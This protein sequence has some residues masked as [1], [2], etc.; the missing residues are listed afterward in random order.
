MDINQKQPNEWVFDIDRAISTWSQFVSRER[1]IRNV[2]LEEL[3][4]HLRDEWE[5]LVRKGLKPEEA[6]EQARK[7][8]GSLDSISSA[9]Q[10]VGFEKV[11]RQ[12]QFKRE[13]GAQFT[14]ALKYVQSAMREVFRHPVFATLNMMGLALALC[15]AIIIGLF[16]QHSLSFDSFHDHA[17]RTYR[18][19]QSRG[20]LGESA[21]PSAG[22]A[23]LIRSEFPGAER[24]AEARGSSGMKRQL[25]VGDQHFM[26][27][28]MLS[29]DSEF[30]DMFS[31]P[32][33]HTSSSSPLSA[34]NTIAITESI[35]E[36]LFGGAD[37]MGQTI[38]YDAT[39]DLVVTAVLFDPPSNTHLP[40]NA[41]VRSFNVP[42]ELNWNRWGD[43]TYVKLHPEAQ[44]VELEKFLD[45]KFKAAQP[46]AISSFKVQP[47][48]DLYLYSE[49]TDNY[50]PTSSPVYVVIFA[51]IGL[52]ILLMAGIN[53]TN[54]ATARTS[55][56]GREVGV[57][58]VVGASRMQLR[59][60]FL[61]E[62][63]F[64]TL[65][66][67]LVAVL[68]AQLVIPEVNT[69]IGESLSLGMANKITFWFALIGVIL[70]LSFGAGIYPAILMA[71]ENPST[72]FSGS[73][74]VGKGRSF[75]RRTLVGLQVAISF[76]MIVSA[77]L[78]SSQLHFIREANL[79][80]DQDQIV[81]IAPRGWSVPQFDAFKQSTLQHTSVVSVAL[82]PP[83]GMGWKSMSWSKKLEGS[84]QGV[85]IEAISVGPDFFETMDMKLVEGRFFQDPDMHLENAPVVVSEAYAAL[86]GGGESMI[87][88]D[89]E[90]SGPII[91]VVK[92][93]HNTSF[94]QGGGLAVYTLEKSYTGTVVVKLASDKIAEG[95]A[96]LDGSWNLHSPDRPFAYEFLDD[97]IQAQYSYEVKLAGIF[98][99]FSTLSMIIAG[100][101][102][103]G[104]ASFT[105]QQ[106]SKEISI[107][108]SLGATDSN[109]VYLLS[110]EF[111]LIVVTGVLVAS[112]LVYLAASD[113]LERFSRHVDLSPTMFILA[114]TACLLVVL[115][116]VSGLAFRAAGSNP[117]DALKCD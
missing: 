74:S 56:R 58:K 22:I 47:I 36:L 53:Y 70:L 66:S 6:F 12:G 65:I 115:L 44:S 16:I 88:L 18:V 48:E 104:L 51:S 54:L 52:F 7:S 76:S 24:V 23:D 96:V 37:P 112:P 62:T 42:V 99:L 40:F 90:L 97:K 39:T 2:D 32:L 92:D 10:E 61:T 89:S 3:E 81:T 94:T 116:P 111:L 49:A 102:L 5:C 55:R 57:R 109:I 93:V 79:G 87:G 72:I 67:L 15:S 85:Q 71:N 77:V 46:G 41:L 117:T 8:I 100:L 31:F 4:I 34:P 68:L 114:A 14:M 63:L 78:I 60:Q 82:G 95:L 11:F 45:D 13:I 105:T 28:R 108:K 19:S 86:F 50:A 69:I 64:L 106:R 1:S 110:K 103:F 35:A 38:R 113:W 73:R 83:L 33:K 75:V 98:N 29:V 20:Q 21:R 91:G 9:Y 84:E 27:D 59:L 26:V 101:G 25:S 107:R 17:D 30:L 80:F 43:Y